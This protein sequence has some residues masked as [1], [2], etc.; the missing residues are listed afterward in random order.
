MENNVKIT[1]FFIPVRNTN[2]TPNVAC[3]K[4][5]RQNMLKHD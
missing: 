1:H 2:P 5:E 3:V 4:W